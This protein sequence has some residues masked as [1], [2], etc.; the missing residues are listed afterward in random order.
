MVLN[1]HH[2]VEVYRKA[3]IWGPGFSSEKMS[4]HSRAGFHCSGQPDI[5]TRRSVAWECP[6]LEEKG[7]L[8]LR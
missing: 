8:P 3:A 6:R 1:S 2:G 4:M 7:A 5:Q